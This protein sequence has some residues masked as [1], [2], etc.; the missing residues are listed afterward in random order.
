M[1]YLLVSRKIIAGFAVG[2]FSFWLHH[3]ISFSP[4]LKNKVELPVVLNAIYELIPCLPSLPGDS[5]TFCHHQ[6]ITDVKNSGVTPIYKEYLEVAVVSSC[7]VLDDLRP[8]IFCGA[9]TVSVQLN[10]SDQIL[11]K[12]YYLVMNFC[13]FLVPWNYSS[14]FIIIY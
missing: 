4:V 7:R 12:T 9:L 2:C 8:F 6:W 11:A 13:D 5:P 3:V 14:I 10:C 1:C